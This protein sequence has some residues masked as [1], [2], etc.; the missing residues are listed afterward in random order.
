MVRINVIIENRHM[1]LWN[2][3]Q[4]HITFYLAMQLS[5]C[6]QLTPEP[7]PK[8]PYISTPIDVYE[9]YYP[10]FIRQYR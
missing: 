3:L 2:G 8:F 5:H 10:K 4:G 1:A 9:S 6:F 7:F